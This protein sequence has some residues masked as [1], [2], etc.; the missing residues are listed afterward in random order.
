MFGS[1]VILLRKVMGT[2]RFNRIRGKVIGLHCKAITNFCNFVG[3]DTKERQNLIRT[4]KSN[5]KTLGLMA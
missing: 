3:I 4:A 2:S 1:L 5:G